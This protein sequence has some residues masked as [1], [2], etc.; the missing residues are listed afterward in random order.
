[1]WNCFGVSPKR[2]YPSDLTDRQW[3]LIEPLLPGPAE[4]PGRPPKH[5][6]R[7]I[8]NAIPYHVRAGGSWRMLPKDFPPW[9]TVYGYFRDWRKDGT[10]DRVHDALRE[11]VRAKEEQRNPQPSAGIVDSQSVKGADTV[12][13]ATRGYDAGKKING[14][15]RHALV[16]TDGRGLVLEPHPASI[17]DRDGGGPLLRVS[18][19]IFPFIQRVFA[20]SGYAGEKVATATLIAVEIVRKNPDQ[21][22]FAVNPRRWVV[23]RFFAWIG[24]NRRL[25]KDFEATIDSARAFLY[26]ASV[27]LLVRRIARAA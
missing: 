17:Q 4:N 2:R 18:R 20:D 1:M 10:L 9:E 24:R 5:S 6:K 22:G 21:I 8:V 3:E 26:A 25:A 13:K 7:E 11:R 15:K 16:D 23:E 14:R 19:R 12:S 27:M